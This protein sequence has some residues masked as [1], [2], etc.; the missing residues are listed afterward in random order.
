MEAKNI[1]VT[2]DGRKGPMTLLYE[3]PYF[4]VTTGPNQ[5]GSSVFT[6]WFRNSYSFHNLEWLFILQNDLSHNLYLDHSPPGQFHTIQVFVPMSG[7]TEW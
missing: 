6:D 7:F 5:M 4:F 1:Q 3:N 2:K